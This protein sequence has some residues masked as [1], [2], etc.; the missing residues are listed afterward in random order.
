MVDI[1]YNLLRI[2]LRYENSQKMSTCFTLKDADAQPMESNTY[3]KFGNPNNISKFW[4]LRSIAQF[5]SLV[6]KHLDNPMY[7][8]FILIENVTAVPQTKMVMYSGSP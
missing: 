7:D 2:F 8:T 6:I 1:I 4:T 5:L 3:N